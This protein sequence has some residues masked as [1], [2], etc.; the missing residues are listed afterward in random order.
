MPLAGRTDFSTPDFGVSGGD[1][2]NL[3]VIVKRLVYRCDTLAVSIGL[4]IDTP[5]GSDVTG[6]ATSPVP[7]TKSATFVVHNEAVHLLPYAGFVSTLGER[8]FYEG[9]VQVDVAANPNHVDYRNNAG[10]GTGDLSE[11]NLLYFDLAGGYWLYRNPCAWTLTGV[12]GM[13]ELHYTTS[14]GY[15]CGRVAFSSPAWLT[16]EN[17]ANR[18]DVL[19]LTV[20]IHVELGKCA[21]GRV[22]AV[23][24]LRTGDD[25]S[26]DSE[27]QPTRM[28]IR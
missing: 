20:G 28:A 21:V 11:Q 26:F 19:D 18:V 16:F 12:A 3:A 2:G 5:T 14:P 15:R 1:V 25:R 9:F 8:F 23:V 22:G 10:P 4:G 17:F 6:F 27:L 7:V 13:V 24:P